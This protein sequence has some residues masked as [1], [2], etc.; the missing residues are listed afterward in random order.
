[1]N[2][3]DPY[4][5]QCKLKFN[6]SNP[7]PIGHAFGHWIVEGESY[8]NPKRPTETM[9][10]CR[11]D[12][13]GNK[14]VHRLSWLASGATTRCNDCRLGRSKKQMTNAFVMNQR[15]HVSSRR[16]FDR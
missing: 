8:P 12:L 16:R 5:S 13:C 1:M 15:T 9:T 10:P 3:G 4:L 11:C 7:P 2:L 14:H 6:R